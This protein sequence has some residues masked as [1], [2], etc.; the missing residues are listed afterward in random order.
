M[1]G[2]VRG[3]SLMETSP[4]HLGGYMICILEDWKAKQRE[5]IWEEKQKKWL[6]THVRNH[7]NRQPQ[8]SSMFFKQWNKTLT[9]KASNV[10]D[11]R[12]QGRNYNSHHRRGATHQV[13]S[14]NNNWEAKAGALPP[15]PSITEGRAER[16]SLEMLLNVHRQSEEGVEYFKINF[17]FQV[18]INSS[19][20]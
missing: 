2:W 13:I 5:K 15:S 8:F 20:S 11:A 14:I 17:I 4:F 9:S 12:H 18:I 16:E 10:K 7:C 19:E 6:T 3:G 1:T